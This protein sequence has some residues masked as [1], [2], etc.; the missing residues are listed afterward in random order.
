MENHFGS[1]SRSSNNSLD[2]LEEENKSPPKTSFFNVTIK[3]Q[4]TRIESE[5]QK[6]SYI[7]SSFQK[8]KYYG[9]SETERETETK[10]TS[11]FRGKF[12]KKIQKT[13]TTSI[14]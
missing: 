3:S 9:Q 1:E 5:T 6:S 12:S 8:P 4:P 7:S 2:G 10:Q 11:Y 14:T 13:F